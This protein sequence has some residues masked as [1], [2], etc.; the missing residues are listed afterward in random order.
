MRNFVLKMNGYN[1]FVQL[2]IIP[3]VLTKNKIVFFKS[4]KTKNV[5]QNICKPSLNKIFCTMINL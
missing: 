4:S 5:F 3:S 1:L 2:F